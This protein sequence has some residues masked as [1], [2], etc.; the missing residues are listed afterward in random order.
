MNLGEQSYDHVELELDNLPLPEKWVLSR[1]STLTKD[2]NKQL[3]RFHFNEAAKIIYDF[4][5]NDFCDW[6]VEIAKSRFYE[7]DV[8]KFQIAKFVSLECIRTVLILLHPFSPFISEELWT[9]F[10][11]VDAND[12]I[13]SPWIKEKPYKDIDS[14]ND[15]VILK[16]IITSIR[17]IRSRMNVSPSKEIDITI[18][19]S[20]DKV[21]FLTNHKYLIKTLAKVNQISFGQNVDKPSQ[22]ASA[23]VQGLELFIPLKGLIDLENE[24]ARL[25]KRMKEVRLILNKIESKLSNQNFLLRAPQSV[26]QKEK[27]NSKKLNEELKKITTNLELI[28]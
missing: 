2:Y 27:R 5:W 6:Y 28:K 15:M 8:E 17:S 21:D 20:K 26:I 1:L 24:S 12:I 3:N 7:N 10:R 19:C 13:V 18:R 4:T 9:N 25:E 23:V 16:D 11:E 14:E 22:S